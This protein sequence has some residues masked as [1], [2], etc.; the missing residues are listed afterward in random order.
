MPIEPTSRTN[1][2]ARRLRHRKIYGASDQRVVQAPESSLIRSSVRSFFRAFGTLLS[3]GGTTNKAMVA[4]FL[5]FFGS[6][7]ILPSFAALNNLDAVYDVT[8]CGQ[9]GENFSAPD[10]QGL[11]LE[12]EDDGSEAEEGAEGEVPVEEVHEGHMVECFIPVED[13]F[14]LSYQSSDVLVSAN[15]GVIVN[16]TVADDSGSVF[17][18]NSVEEYV[19][20]EGDTIDTIAEAHGV[21]VDTIKFNNGLKSDTIKIGQ[22]LNIMPLDGVLI[23]VTGD[24]SLKD[25][26]KE[27]DVDPELLAEKNDVT[28][29][30][31]FKKGEQIILPGEDQL[32][33]AK[34][35]AEEEEKRLLAEAAKKRA[36]AA[37]KAK[38][39]YSGAVTNTTSAAYNPQTLNVATASGKSMVWPTKNP[40]VTQ[41]YKY[42]HAALDIAYTSGDH[43]TAIVSVLPGKV[44]KSQGGW[45]GGYGNMVLVD[46][47][48]GLVTRYAHMREIYVS[49]GQYVG[50]GQAVGWMGRTGRVYG[51]TGLHLHFETIL[52][53]R[54]VN[55]YIYL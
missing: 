37:A 49:V 12:S 39:A 24:A 32:A 19:V 15:D 6:S 11:G 48:N 55:P 17:E 16:P 35:R 10:A 26:A 7:T 50:Q 30:A 2:H 31:Q 27:H 3:L 40:V 20:Q 51:R 8:A 13:E 38:T 52:N 21:S 47:G 5:V 22:K 41:G 28:L 36:E 14:L 1:K 54:R 9:G 23:T 34:K 4:L 33:K 46:H 29:R 42:G 44:I 43:T 25:V 18:E 45:N 53:G